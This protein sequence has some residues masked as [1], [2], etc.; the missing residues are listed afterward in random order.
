MQADVR[1]QPDM[2]WS[3][4]GEEPQ[5]HAYGCEYSSCNPPAGW[6]MCVFAGS[7]LT[8][9]RWTRVTQAG[10]LTRA[11]KDATEANCCPTIVLMQDTTLFL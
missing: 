1:L 7:S 5:V 8:D 6:I 9:C 11:Q 10:V 2:Q 3:L 4:T